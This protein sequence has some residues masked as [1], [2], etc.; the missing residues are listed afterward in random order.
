MCVRAQRDGGEDGRELLDRLTPEHMS[1]DLT[2]RARD[3]LDGHLD[4]PLDELPRDDD[5]LVSLVTDL[6]MRAEREPA[7]RAAM[8]SNFL[9]LDLKRI[10]DQIDAAVR[11]GGDLPVD[12]QRRR[13]ELAERVFGRE[14]V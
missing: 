11:A 8:E 13:A 14:A 2:R 12:L 7:P 5:E 1:S 10:E 9:E 3:W 4:R 6:V